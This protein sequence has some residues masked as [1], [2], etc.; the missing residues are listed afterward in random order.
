MHQANHKPGHNAA[1]LLAV[2]G[3]LAH[4]DHPDVHLGV[5]AC[6]PLRWQSLA[7]L[8]LPY[9]LRLVQCVSVWRRGGPRAQLFNAAKYA[10]SLPALVL[11]AAEHEAHVKG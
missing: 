6:H 3:P 2:P 7:A 9:S 1:C 8:I 4:P 11:T 5:A 10:S